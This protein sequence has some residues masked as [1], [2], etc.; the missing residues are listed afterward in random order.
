MFAIHASDLKSKLLHLFD[1]QFRL[2]AGGAFVAL[3]LVAIQYEE[4]IAPTLGEISQGLDAMASDFGRKL[5][6][7]TL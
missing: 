4:V 6:S 7:F 2:W 5:T 3:A 1:T